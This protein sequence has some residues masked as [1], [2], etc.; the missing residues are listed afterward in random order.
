MPFQVH[1]QTA[2]VGGCGGWACSQVT[3]LCVCDWHGAVVSVQRCTHTHTH[4][5]LQLGLACL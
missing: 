1:W 2:V 5:S 3:S 4:T